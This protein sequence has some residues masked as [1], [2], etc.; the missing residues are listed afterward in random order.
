[1]NLEILTKDIKLDPT[2]EDVEEFA[3]S[4]ADA[5]R[6]QFTQ[7]VRPN[8]PLRL[9]NIGKVSLFEAC[10]INLGIIPHQPR[11]SDIPSNTMFTFLQGDFVE[12]WLRFLIRQ[13]FKGCKLDEQ[14][15]LNFGGVIGH[16]DFILTHEGE[17]VLIEAKSA[18]TYYFDKVSKFGVSDERGYFSQLT[19]YQH[20][21]GGIP[22]YWL[23]LHKD[24]SKIAIIPLDA[25]K[26]NDNLKKLLAKAEAF[27]Q[28]TSEEI[29]YRSIMPYPPSIEKTRNGEYVL[30]E[31][32]NIKLYPNSIVKH[33][34]YSYIL[35]EG[36]TRYG[37]KRLYITD[38]NYP[39]EYQEFKPNGYQQALKFDR[40]N[41]DS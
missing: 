38:Y 21:L 1:M 15:T 3:S 7:G 10:A 34:E 37:K 4:T 16:C 23:F 8:P 18:N 20:C 27:K 40:R 12:C 2:P 35:T 14:Q 31:D 25:T 36:K 13:A 29:L 28:C 5:I 11:K 24:T 6:L 19:A 17:T 26:A 41:N 32:G 9:S 39:Q 22:A 30:D 33:P